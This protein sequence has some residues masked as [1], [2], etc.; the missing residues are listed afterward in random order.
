MIRPV[1]GRKKVAI[2]V[3]LAVLV[4]VG[5]WQVMRDS[6]RTAVFE[7]VVPPV[8]VAIVA[9]QYAAEMAGPGP[10]WPGLI[11]RAGDDVQRVLRA[12]AGLWLDDGSYLVSW[13]QHLDPCPR[14]ELGPQHCNRLVAA[15]VDPRTGKLRVVEEL[16]ALD[17]PRLPREA[18]QRVTLVG[19]VPTHDV[20]LPVVM[21][22][23]ADLT[24]PQPVRLPK[25]DGDHPGTHRSGGARVI[26]IGDWDYAPYSDVNDDSV[27]SYGYL[28]RRAG[29]DDWDKVLVERRLSDIWVSR[30]GRALLGVQQR[31]GDPCDFCENDP[32]RQIVEIDPNK[33]EIVRRYGVPTGY[34]K[35]WK[36]AVVDKMDDRVLV[37]FTKRGTNLGV[38][39]YDGT[40]SLVP[41][42]TG[43]YT[44]WQGAEDRIEARLTKGTA[45]SGTYTLTWVHGTKR[46][47]LPGELRHD[48]VADWPGIPGSLVPPQ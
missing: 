11:V 21:T 42:T 33:G 4:G 31:S 41:G 16:G 10:N 7:S 36:V 8:K 1:A 15:I 44:W 14:P 18:V 45:G 48:A 6:G 27:E 5:T 37:R 29:T 26:S 9:P 19:T 3:V 30:D 22:L 23:D 2:G 32:G 28:R 38:W 39:Q 40:W 12:K 17:S 13:Y 43:P 47:P 35:S 46:T 34:T 24:D 25:Y 20:P